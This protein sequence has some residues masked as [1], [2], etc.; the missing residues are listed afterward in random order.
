MPKN[1]TTPTA[2][3]IAQKALNG[4][5]EPETVEMPEEELSAFDDLETLLYSRIDAG[6]YKKDAY[7]IT[8]AIGNLIQQRIKCAFKA[9]GL[10]YVGD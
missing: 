10:N 8:E 5:K 4:G 2:H 7:A 9:A 1:E 6:L 3:E